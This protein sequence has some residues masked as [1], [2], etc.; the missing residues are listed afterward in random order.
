MKKENQIFLI[1]KLN[2][3]KEDDIG[4]LE[5]KKEN[6]KIHF[7]NKEDKFLQMPPEYPN[8]KKNIPQ[9]IRKGFFLR[10]DER[11]DNQFEE[12]TSLNMIEENLF[13]DIDLENE[14]IKI[15]IKIYLSH[16]Q[17][18]TFHYKIMHKIASL[19]SKIFLFK[20]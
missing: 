5:D 4:G 12:L 3:D 10:E 6:K 11:I 2:I 13:V 20:K 15:P 19:S 8:S 7:K 1:G 14:S 9:C 18:D 16:N 17:C